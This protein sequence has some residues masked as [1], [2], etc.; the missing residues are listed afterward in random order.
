MF[1]QV[2]E[3]K[4]LALAEL[5]VKKK[6]A[7]LINSKHHLLEELTKQKDMHDLCVEDTE[8]FLQRVNIEHTRLECPV[9]LWKSITRSLDKR[10]ILE[11]DAD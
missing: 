8:I 3:E 11:D 4:A 5:K 7:A 1:T 9:S 6:L 10:A 2:K